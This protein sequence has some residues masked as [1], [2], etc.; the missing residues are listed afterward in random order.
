MH[1][2]QGGFAVLSRAIKV[3]WHTILRYTLLGL[4]STARYSL[5]VRITVPTVQALG[6]KMIVQV[7]WPLNTD[8]QVSLL[9]T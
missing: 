9:D 7:H 2:H 4:G 5:G 1:V 8:V 6:Q 3:V